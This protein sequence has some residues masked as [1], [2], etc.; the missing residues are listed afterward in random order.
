MENSQGG[1]RKGAMARDADGNGQGGYGQREG[2]RRDGNGQGGYGQRDG[3]R[4]DG[5]NQG[6]YGQG[7][8]GKSGQLQSEIRDVKARSGRPWSEMVR[9][10]TKWSGRLRSERWPET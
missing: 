6:G 2:Q 1:Q 10:V 3:Q 7:N 4:R 5:N 9:D 8:G